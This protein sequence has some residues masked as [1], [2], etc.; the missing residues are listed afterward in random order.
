MAR[1]VLPPAF[2]GASLGRIAGKH[3]GTSD[4][5]AAVEHQGQGHQRTVCPLLFG[6]SPRGFGVGGGGALE[7]GVGQVIE[8]DGR[9]Q[10]EQVLEAGEQRVLDGGTVAQ[11][12]VGDAVE[13]HQGHGLEVHVEPFAQRAAGGEPLVG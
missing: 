7:I 12:Q 1:S 13:P 11:Q 5:S 9:R 4:K 6:P 10:A 3:L 8:G 2:A